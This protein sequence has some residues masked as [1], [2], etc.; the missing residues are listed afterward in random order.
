MKKYDYIENAAERPT[1][2]TKSAALENDWRAPIRREQA[3]YILY[4]TYILYL[5]KKYI[6]DLKI[7]Y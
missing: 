6:R 1:R 4:I 5:D 7:N 2:K 3:T